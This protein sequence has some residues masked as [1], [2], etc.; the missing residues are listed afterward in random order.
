MKAPA[1]TVMISSMSFPVPV[2]LFLMG[3]P[4]SDNSLQEHS[5]GA[6][7]TL[8]EQRHTNCVEYT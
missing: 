5:T 1:V 6:A 2:Q 8:A 3:F 7:A 4:H